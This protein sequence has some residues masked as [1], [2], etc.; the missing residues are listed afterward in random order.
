MKKRVT[1]H[2]VAK[3][4]GVS[5]GVVSAVINDTPGIRVSEEKRKRVL[6]A[7]AELN[8]TVDA[9][10]RSMRLGKSNCIAAYGNLD[11]S[12]FLQMLQGVQQACTAR[13]YH[14]LL[15]GHNKSEENKRW[16]IELYNQRRIDGLLTKDVTGYSKDTWIRDVH[17]ADMPYVSVEGYPDR[18]DVTS[19]L[20]DY[21]ESVKLAL[22]HLHEA[23]ALVPVYVELYN[24]PVYAPNW[25]DVHRRKAYLH[26]M[27]E[28]GWEPVIHQ[29]CDEGED[30]S[31]WWQELLNRLERPAALLTNWSSGSRH[32]YEAAYRLGMRIGS[33]LYVMAADDTR[34]ANDYLVP[35]LS[36]VEVPY[37]EMGRAGAERLLDMIEGRRM[38]ERTK[39]WVPA[40]LTVRDSTGLHESRK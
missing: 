10:A 33:D 31:S 24:P 28:R 11:N 9:Q 35:S 7:I 32:I 37:L 15:Y 19:V 14:L 36:A 4:S 18:Q 21:E 20:M 26:W 34:Q 23:T 40:R 30:Q 17:E 6:V 38:D 8:Y 12:F 39:L 13:G 29:L 1:S 2:D 16:L 3:L 25:G 5:R 27:A 22:D